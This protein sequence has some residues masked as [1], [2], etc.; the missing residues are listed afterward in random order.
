[1]KHQ[2]LTE[3]RKSAE[4][5]AANLGTGERMAE[6]SMRCNST[7]RQ[8]SHVSASALL[9]EDRNRAQTNKCRK[10]HSTGWRSLTCV[11]LVLLLVCSLLHH[12]TGNAFVEN[13]ACQWWKA[14]LFEQMGELL[15]LRTS[16]QLKQPSSSPLQTLWLSGI[17]CMASHKH[18]TPPG[19]QLLKWLALLQHLSILTS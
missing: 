1:M 12:Q 18:V 3:R 10:S 17:P 4:V 9:Q 15:L 14:E 7:G 11:L 16:A 5:L 13:E 2:K 8:L 6:Q 19:Q